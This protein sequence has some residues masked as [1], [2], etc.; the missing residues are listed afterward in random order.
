MENVI[1]A[2]EMVDMPEVVQPQVATLEQVTETT[3]VATPGAAQP[4][5]AA[6]K[7]PSDAEV[8]QLGEPLAEPLAKPEQAD[9]KIVDT[10]QAPDL[11]APIG[12]ELSDTEAKLLNGQMSKRAKD[13]GRR[14]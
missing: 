8:A 7:A 9:E 6:P 2:G 5:Q 3:P 4:E 13:W 11:S 14:G 10:K 12:Y 1:D